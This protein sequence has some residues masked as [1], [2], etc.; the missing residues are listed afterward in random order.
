MKK[1]DLI[2]KI[3]TM[4]YPQELQKGWSGS[5]PCF[6]Y[7]PLVGG[8]RLT[9]HGHC[10]RTTDNGFVGGCTCAF[11]GLHIRGKLPQKDLLDIAMAF[12]GQL[13]KQ[14]WYS[15]WEIGVVSLLKLNNL[16]KQI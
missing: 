12:K 10:W 16:K 9:I 3:R 6:N 13:D 7:S 1:T 15:K 5:C 8:N 2:K 14:E 4:D 11:N